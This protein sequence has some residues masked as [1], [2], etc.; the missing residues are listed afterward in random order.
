M[1][2]ERRQIVDRQSRVMRQESELN[3]FIKSLKES[4]ADTKHSLS[5][6]SI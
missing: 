3:K 1:D 4:V 6:E 2:E 5:K